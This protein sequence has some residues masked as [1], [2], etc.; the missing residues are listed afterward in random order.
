[1][2]IA[3]RRYDGIEP[4][5]VAEVVRRVTNEAS[6]S[7]PTVEQEL[8]RWADEGGF[9]PQLTETAGSRPTTSRMLGM[10]WLFP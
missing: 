5:A 3:I 4:S 8:D 10:E 2:Y 6:A 9:I 7:A 1:M